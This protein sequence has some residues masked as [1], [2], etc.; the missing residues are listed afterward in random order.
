MS[1]TT[2]IFSDFTKHLTNAYDI[3]KSFSKEI[4]VQIDEDSPLT[5]EEVVDG[6]V[7]L[8]PQIFNQQISVATGTLKINSE[9]IIILKSL[10]SK[11]EVEE[12]AF[13]DIADRNEKIQ[14]LS[15]RLPYDPN[16]A[17]LMIMGCVIT[18]NSFVNSTKLIH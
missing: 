12:K 10:C 13:K 11:M 1:T 14:S 3:Q 18:L 6:I 5:L 4:G 17:R 8:A 16:N 7:N 2:T 9:K 15:D